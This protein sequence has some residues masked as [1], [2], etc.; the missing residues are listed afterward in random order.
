MIIVYTVVPAVLGTL[1]VAAGVY[2]YKRTSDLKNISSVSA[3]SETPLQDYDIDLSK[4][5]I[6]SEFKLG[7]EEAGIG[8]SRNGR[9]GPSDFYN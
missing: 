8:H 3:R 9:N 7:D 1:L 2:M 5:E 6:M 4:K